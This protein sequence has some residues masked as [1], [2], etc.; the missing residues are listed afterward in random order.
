MSPTKNVLCTDLYQLTMAAAYFDNNHNDLS[1]FELFVRKLPENRS[2]L[3]AAGIEQIVD[4]LLSLKFDN[5]DIEYLQNQPVFKNVSQ[6]FFEYLKNF[7]FS[8]DMYAVEEGTIFFPNEPVLRITAPAIEAQIIETYLLSMFNF[9]TMIA[10]KAA[11]IISV[12]GGRGVVEFGTRRAH[13]PD[14]GILAARAAYI[15]GCIG[16]SNTLAG[17][18]FG[19]PV[20]G[21]MAH[22]WVMSFDSEKEAFEAYTKVF[23]EGNTLL[24][25]TYDTAEAAKMVA[26]LP[27]KVQA[28]RL[29]SGDFCSLSKQVRKILDTAGKQ[30]ILILAS[31]DLNEYKI[32][33]LLHNASEIDLFGVGTELA[34][35]KDAPALAGVYKLVEQQKNGQTLYRAKYSENKKSYPAQKQVYR[36]LKP[37]GTF[38]YDTIAVDGEYNNTDALQLLQPVLIKGCVSKNYKPDLKISRENCLK[39]FEKLPEE[40]KLLDTTHQYTVKISEKLEN[41]ANKLQNS[42]CLQV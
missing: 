13:S 11:R 39:S 23:P 42:R 8:G 10:S 33:E 7:R 37:D 19:I 17:K 21:T 1:T 15:G 18:E 20:Y 25:D 12:A 35:S 29:D 38:N 40:F 4:Y 36:Y 30:E 32:A 34:T 9:Q 22:S 16:T 24:I 31:G 14:A 5:D 26:Q 28:V 6:Q 27:F 3:V 41:L 2:Y